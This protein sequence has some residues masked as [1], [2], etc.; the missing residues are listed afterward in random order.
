MIAPVHTHTPCAPS[1]VVDEHT[2]LPRL[3]DWAKLPVVA[4]RPRIYVYE[5]PPRFSAWYDVKQTEEPLE[6][7]FWERLMS[8]AH[9]VAVRKKCTFRRTTFLRAER[10]SRSRETALSETDLVDSSTYSMPHDASSAPW[11]SP[12]SLAKF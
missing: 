9:R 8:S 4:P 3:V 1:Q 11:S 2:A 6:A 5:L 12:L 7:V 10:K